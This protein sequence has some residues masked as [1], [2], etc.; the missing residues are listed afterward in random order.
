MRGKLIRLCDGSSNITVGC[1]PRVSS[2]PVL[3]AIKADS[4]QR[5]HKI[6]FKLLNVDKIN[7]TAMHH[8]AVIRR[9]RDALVDMPAKVGLF[10]LGSILLECMYGPLVYLEHENK[11]RGHEFNIA[12]A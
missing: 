6:S 7:G 4:E 9:L 5:P 11:P 8:D 3:S 1:H 2:S 10:G 12:P